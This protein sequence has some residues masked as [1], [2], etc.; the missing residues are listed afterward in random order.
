MVAAH[1][2][3]TAS[4]FVARVTTSSNQPHPDPVFE[5]PTDGNDVQSEHVLHVFKSSPLPSSFIKV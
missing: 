5:D 4:Y 2:V 3:R 1:A